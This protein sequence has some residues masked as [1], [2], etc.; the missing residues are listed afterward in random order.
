MKIS[1]AFT[2]LLV[3]SAC[4]RQLQARDD[5]VATT[6]TVIETEPV[7]QFAGVAPVSGSG[8]L[9]PTA[10]TSKTAS[11]KTGNGGSG[12]DVITTKKNSGSTANLLTVIA[13]MMAIL[14]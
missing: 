14:I 6:N 7:V 8:T 4:A 13:L 1:A 11:V 12:K 9:V 10:T 5:G 3:S 2:A